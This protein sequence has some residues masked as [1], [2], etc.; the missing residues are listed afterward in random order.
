M[1]KLGALKMKIKVHEKADPSWFG[2]LVT[3]KDNISFTK[4]DLV[5]Y[6]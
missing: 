1:R 6:M 3:L 5:D 2:Y 4:A